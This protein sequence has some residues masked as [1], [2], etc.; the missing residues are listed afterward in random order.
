MGYVLHY[1]ERSELDYYSNLLYLYR[2]KVQAKIQHR[3]PLMT[4]LCYLYW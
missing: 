4:N 2:Q 1:R 3:L